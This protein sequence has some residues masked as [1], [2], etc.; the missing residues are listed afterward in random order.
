MA[1]AGTGKPS[2]IRLDKRVLAPEY[3]A[4][5]SQR[6]YRLIA[7]VIKADQVI[8]LEHLFVFSHPSQPCTIHR[9]TLYLYPPDHL[10]LHL[11]NTRYLPQ[12]AMTFPQKLKSSLSLQ[13]SYWI[14]LILAAACI[15]AYGADKCKCTTGYRYF[16]GSCYLL[17]KD[18]H[19]FSRKCSVCSHKQDGYHNMASVKSQATL[20]FLTNWMGERNG[21]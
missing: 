18:S 9:E 3:R 19:A 4:C 20:E 12:E 16:E 8:D 6:Q 17:T 15:L 13:H 5:T 21:K 11:Y 7:W 14:A 10:G 1:R 2:W